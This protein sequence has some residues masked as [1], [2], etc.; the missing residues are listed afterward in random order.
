MNTVQSAKWD[1]MV[2]GFSDAFNPARESVSIDYNK[3]N[4]ASPEAIPTATISLDY[5]YAVFKEAT[6]TYNNIL[7]V[8]VTRLED[9]VVISLPSGFLFENQDKDYAS[10]NLTPPL[11]V[12]GRVLVT[13]LVNVLQQLSNEVAIVGHVAPTYNGSSAWIQSLKQASAVQE[14]IYKAGYKSVISI[15]GLGS[16]RYGDIDSTILLK[17]RLNLADRV[18][19]EVKMQMREAIVDAS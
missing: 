15:Y 16:S 10:S 13:N 17:V 18:D 8:H 5:V 6:S 14:I 1:S 11:K 19:I 2:V 3:T 4:V 9:R 7:G 12:D